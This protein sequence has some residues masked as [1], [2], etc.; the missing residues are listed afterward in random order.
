MKIKE[1]RQKSEK[2]LQKLLQELRERLRKLRFDLVSGKVK[3]VKEIQQTRKDIARILTILN[4]R[5]KENA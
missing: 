5:K 1:L 4:E 3:N 2:E